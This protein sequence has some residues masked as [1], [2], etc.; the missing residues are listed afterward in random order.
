[1]KAD[2]HWCHGWI[3]S[4]N[5]NC[6]HGKDRWLPPGHQGQC[7][8]VAELPDDNELH[9]LTDFE[10]WAVQDSNLRPPACKAGALTS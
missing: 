2:R 4:L 7:Q 6:R 3:K 5:Q 9:D 8:A 10:W 1:M